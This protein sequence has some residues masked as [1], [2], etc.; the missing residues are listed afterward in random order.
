[1]PGTMMTGPVYRDTT[2]VD[3][4]VTGSGMRGMAGSFPQPQGVFC[5]MLSHGCVI[6]AYTRTL[7]RVLYGM[8]GPLTP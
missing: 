1:M 7:C 8:P 2:S 4:V 6:S 3:Y 5:L